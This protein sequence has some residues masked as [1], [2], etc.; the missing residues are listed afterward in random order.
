[1]SQ[2]KG[3]SYYKD[4]LRRYIQYVGEL[5]GSTGLEHYDLFS[6]ASFTDTEWEALQE[7]EAEG[8]NEN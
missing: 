5:E 3:E 6:N 4:L 1:M 7:L 8:L 2:S